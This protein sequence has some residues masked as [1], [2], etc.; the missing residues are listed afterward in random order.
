MALRSFL[1]TLT[2]VTSYHVFYNTPT[3]PPLLRFYLQVPD[4]AADYLSCPNQ[5][6]MTEHLDV[7]MPL[8]AELM[9][10]AMDMARKTALFL[11]GWTNWALHTMT[12]T[13]TGTHDPRPDSPGD[14]L[15]SPVEGDFDLSEAQYV[16]HGPHH[17]A[18][19]TEVRA[20]QASRLSGQQ[21]FAPLIWEQLV[22]QPAILDNLLQDM[23]DPHAAL[24]AALAALTMAFIHSYIH[25]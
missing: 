21:H 13:S 1:S 15:T 18:Q 4:K 20:L 12:C 22:Q 16:A 5:P 17:E 25:T 24:R 9:P 11:D 2:E 7:G 6:G 10:K 23:K 19:E 3:P 14:E 8:A